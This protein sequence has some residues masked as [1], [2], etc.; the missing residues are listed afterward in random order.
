MRL[1][2][3]PIHGCK[4]CS[5]TIQIQIFDGSMQ[6]VEASR[7]GE[8]LRQ[9]LLHVLRQVVAQLCSARVSHPAA[10]CRILGA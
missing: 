4:S 7:E 8:H 6:V 2:M 5:P 10:H 1:A 9:T 3:S